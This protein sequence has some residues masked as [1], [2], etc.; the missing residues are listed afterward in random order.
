LKHDS[1]REKKDIDRLEKLA[2]EYG[3]YVTNTAAPFRNT[4]DS[5]YVIHPLDGH[6]NAKAHKIFAEVIYEYLK[7]QNLLT[8][9]NARNEADKEGRLKEQ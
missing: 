6:P 8:V 2:G 5:E 3:L 9:N 7:G 1:K 4:K